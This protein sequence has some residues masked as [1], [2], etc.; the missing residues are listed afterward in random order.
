M[1]HD[2][3]TDM[4]FI[5]RALDINHHRFYESLT[6]AFYEANVRYDVMPTQEFLCSVG[7][8]ES[9]V[10]ILERRQNLKKIIWLRD[11]MPVT[12][13][14]HGGIEQFLC[15]SS[16]NMLLVCNQF[17]ITPFQN[18]IKLDGSNILVDKKG[19]VYMTD[20]V[21]EKNPDI[22]RDK[23]IC[24]LKQSL[25]A[26]TIK[27]I[28]RDESDKYGHVDRMMAIADDGTLIT[29]LSWE[30]LNFLRVGNNIFVAQLGKP[31]DE[32][33]IRRIQEAYPNCTIYPI[34]HAQ[35]LTRL[36][37]SLHRATWNTLQDGYRN[38]RVF[39]P[40]KRH[41]FNP[42]SADAFT[43]KRI[44]EL[45]EYYN[46]NHFAI[47]EWKAFFRAFK[48]FWFYEVE[49]ND[50][51]H[52]PDMLFG[53]MMEGMRR[54]LKSPYFN[55]IAK[56]QNICYNLS[57]YIINIPKLI[58]PWDTLFHEYEPQRPLQTFFIRFRDCEAKITSC[59]LSKHLFIDDEAELKS[60][61]EKEAKDAEERND[62]TVYILNYPC[63][64][65]YGKSRI[66]H[67]RYELR[68]CVDEKYHLKLV[69]YYDTT[70][71]HFTLSQYAQWRCRI[72]SFFDYCTPKPD[73]KTL[74]KYK[75]A[76]VWRFLGKSFT[77]ERLEELCSDYGI[78]PEQALGWKD[79]WL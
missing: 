28:P 29:D 14:K 40:S 73:I 44:R 67:Y 26:R 66:S 51:D 57:R 70:M 24:D 33:A 42:F 32:P 45:V 35:S 56:L 15:D 76:R 19:C 23:L 37:G 48:S 20:I 59:I 43:E 65:D 50:V 41:P 10:G 75:A 64:W 6:D 30:Y 12:V 62:G 31:T 16:P 77:Q 79:Y 39:K 72:M 46:G 69:I 3:Q 74:V 22:P 5:S 55:D 2:S 47:N 49:H 63:Q 11:Y 36:G 54:F 7:I 1:L 13:D 78:T 71:G 60:M 4:V 8:F 53:K 52:D 68:A 38:S 9:S 21:F 61:V 25:N 27:F 17:G 18:D 58:I 34:K